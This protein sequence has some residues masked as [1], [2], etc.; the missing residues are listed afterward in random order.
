MYNTYNNTY[1]K[2]TLTDIINTVNNV[3]G[4]DF[5]PFFNMYVDGRDRLPLTEY[6]AK[7]GLDLQIKYNEELP[8]YAYVTQV[9]EESLGQETPVKISAVNG[10]GIAKYKE[11]RKIAKEWKSGD[12][13]E[14]TY[15]ET[16]EDGYVT[17]P[18]TIGELPVN[19]PT[20][21]EIVVQITESAEMTKLQR[22]ILTDIFSR[23]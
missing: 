14:L 23:N 13:V 16:G 4:K 15:T 2:Y 3:A 8:T 5:E 10:V 18:V 11:L 19:P 7:S 1:E 21:P 17:K 12:I 9:I 6:F 20:T 22:D